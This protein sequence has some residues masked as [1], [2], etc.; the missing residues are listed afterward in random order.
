MR[1]WH[2]GLRGRAA[3][4]LRRAWRYGPPVILAAS[5][6]VLIVLGAL[7]LWLPVA[8]VDGLS[9]W[10]ALF[11]A[12]SAVTVTGLV[13]VDTG[14]QLTLF[15]QSVVL[16]LI[17]LGGLGLMTFAALTVMALGGRFGLRGQRLVR[18]ALDQTSPGDVLALVRHVALLAFTLEAVGVALL[19]TVWVPEMGWAEGSG[20]AC[21][22]PFP[23]STTPASACCRRVSR[24]GPAIRWSTWSSPRCS[25]SAGLVSPW[26]WTCGA[27]AVSVP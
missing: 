24:P 20:S 3:R 7:L 27:V 16:V 6:A 14:A 17:H 10:Q 12:C 21:S 25:S 19:A 26:W 11:T 2:P 5:F 9:L 8:S 15:G 23:L 13:V 22:T 4:Q 18:E 1:T